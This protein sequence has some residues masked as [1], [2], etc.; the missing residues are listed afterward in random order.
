M[1]DSDDPLIFLRAPRGLDRRR[2]R[3]FHKRLCETAAGGNR[4][5][6][7]LTDDREL[8]RL[9]LQFLG[10]DYPTDVLSFPEPGPDGFLGEM[11]ISVERAAAQAQQFGHSTD[12]EIEILML[13]G[14][15]H[16]IGMDHETDKGQM[17]RAEKR[18][19][20]TLGLASGLVERVR[21]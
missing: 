8:R 14:A 10:H 11:A 20:M 5:C 16:L 21:R 9:N 2:L 6:C 3:D 19:R 4:F 12:E 17:A 1:P 7:L 13:H 18:W 15:L